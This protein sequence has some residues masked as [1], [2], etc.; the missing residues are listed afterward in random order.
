MHEAFAI[1]EI[2]DGEA[3]GTIH[4]YCSQECRSAG[5]LEYEKREGGIT[6]GMDEDFCDGTICEA[7]RNPL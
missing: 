4:W 2:D 3:N 6:L 7:C 1:Y 5:I